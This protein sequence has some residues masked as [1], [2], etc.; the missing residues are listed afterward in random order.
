MARLTEIHRQQHGT[1]FPGVVPLPA[2]FGL[3][4]R[5]PSQRVLSLHAMSLVNEPESEV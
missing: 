1:G 3:Q 4:W 5:S 2:P